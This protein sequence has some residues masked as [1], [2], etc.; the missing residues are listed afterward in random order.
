LSPGCL[1]VGAPPARKE[2]AVSVGF[3]TRI[4]QAVKGTPLALP[5]MRARATLRRRHFPGSARYWESWYSGGGTSGPGTYGR[6]ALFKATEMNRFVAQHGIA[7]VVDFGCGDGHQLSLAEYPRYVGL[8]VSETALSMCRARFSDDPNKRFLLYDAKTFDPLDVRAD[9][10]VS[11]D[12]IY[13]LVEDA[14]FENYMRHLF[15]SATR[16]VALYTSDSDSYSEIPP[17]EVKHRP[18]LRYVKEHFR[19][20]QLY[21]KVM[22]PYPYKSQFDGDVTTESFSN[23][24]FYSREATGFI[25]PREALAASGRSGASLS[26]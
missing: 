18:V 14:V 10:S 12:V 7:S 2:A 17:P 19:D 4:K 15:A 11:L 23:F 1:S 5:A 24:Y 3:S 22:N 26:Q 16:F 6:L 21:N 20:W 9:L 25:Q 8:D 13:H